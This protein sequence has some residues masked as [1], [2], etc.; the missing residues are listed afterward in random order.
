MPIIGAAAGIGGSIA[1]GIIGAHAASK[2][3]DTLA[4]GATESEHQ[5]NVGTNN[6]TNFLQNAWSQDQGRQNPY[7][8]LGTTSAHGLQGL[9][10]E[11]FTAPTLA[12]AQQ[13]PGY[14][15]QLQQGTNAINQNAAA[16]GTLMSGNTGKALMDYGQGLASTTYG[17]VYNRALQSYLTNLQGLTQGTQI[18]QNSATALGSESVPMASTF[19]NIQQR[20]AEESAQQNNNIAS[21][22][23][24]GYLGHAQAIN[25]M[26]GGITGALGGGGFNIAGLLHPG[27]SGGPGNAADDSTQPWQ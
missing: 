10:S 4:K 6:A 24:S 26:I 23:A 25:G 13:D 1:S 15:F 20:G 2:A 16:N 12:Q 8:D 27:G 18:G 19:G 21:A 22:R 11:G 5:I 3:S 9:L 14:Q 17:N 7:L